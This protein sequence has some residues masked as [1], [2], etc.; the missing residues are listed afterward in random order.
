MAGG[1]RKGKRPTESGTSPRQQQ[2]A[3]EFFGTSVAQQP[4]SNRRGDVAYEAR[5]DIQA[6]PELLWRLQS[7]VGDWPRWDASLARAEADG[8]F[9][10]GA[11]VTMHMAD[12]I[13]VSTLRDV[14]ENACFSD[15]VAVDGH[16]I[17]VHHRLSALPAGGTQV[18]YRAEITG[19]RAAQWGER[20]T[21]DFP[22][23]LAA[24]KTLAEGLAR[25]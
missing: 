24:L 17:R 14:R 7:N 20:V 21:G 13:I 22:Q 16:L 3:V 5:I 11:R 15:E 6:A 25:P 4:V 12:G 8:P 9:A 19:P 1:F 18:L 10:D 23:V 2:V